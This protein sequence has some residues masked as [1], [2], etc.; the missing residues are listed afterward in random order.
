MSFRPP[1]YL[2]ADASG[3]DE[4]LP[5]NHLAEAGVHFIGADS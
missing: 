2:P 5:L 4:L 1:T 3:P